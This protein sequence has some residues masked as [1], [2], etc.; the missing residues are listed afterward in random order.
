MAAAATADATASAATA[1][2]AVTIAA[3]AAATASVA[4]ATA[5]AAT[6][7]VE[8]M[9][10]NVQSTV[11]SLIERILRVERKSQDAVNASAQAEATSAAM[12]AR[13]SRVESELATLKRATS[14]GRNKVDEFNFDTFDFIT[15]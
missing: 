14:G 15:Q 4:A 1:A 8:I 3:A 13:L 9:S 6:V 12:Q 5:P 2:D 10:T 7:A 11:D